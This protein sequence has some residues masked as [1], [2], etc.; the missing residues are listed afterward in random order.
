MKGIRVEPEVE[1]QIDLNVT[2]YIPDEYISDANQKI[3]IYQNIALCQNEQDI[4]NI[5]DEII[6]RFGNMPSELENLI[7]VARIKYLAKKLKISKIASKKTAVVFTF[8]PKKFELD[9]TELVKKYG[10]KIKFSSGIKP[11]VTLEIGSTNERQILNDVTDF[12][13]SSGT[14]TK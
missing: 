4:Q 7:A 1:L 5:I 12:L 3:E 6:D 10:N 9:I 11:M 8:E 14:S 13:V 2:S